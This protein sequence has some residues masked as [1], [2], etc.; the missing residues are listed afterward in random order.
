VHD[1]VVAE[2]SQ[3]GG[4]G[5][6]QLTTVLDQ[7]HVGST[8]NPAVIA[9]VKDLLNEPYTSDKFNFGGYDPVTV[10]Y[11]NSFGCDPLLT[12][13][14]LPQV[15]SSSV[16]SFGYP[17]PGDTTWTAGDTIHVTV[18]GPDVDTIV[19]ALR[20]GTEM[21][22]TEKQPGPEAA[23]SIEIPENLEGEIPLLA[24]GYSDEPKFLGF[25][26]DTLTILPQYRLTGISV[27]PT[28]IFSNT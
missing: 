28:K 6:N 24:F 15:R 14:E 23:F 7:M 11:N 20:V 3:K 21:I 5:G 1:L 17:P 25:V 19:L 13:K 10:N 2:Q 8:A 16:L 22:Y 27:F 9:L 4:L 18:S 12:E 26:A